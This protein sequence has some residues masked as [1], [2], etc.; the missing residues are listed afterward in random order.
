[1]LHHDRDRRTE[2]DR[3]HRGQRTQADELDHSGRLDFDRG[4][5][6]AGRGDDDRG[7][8]GDGQ[9]L[10][11]E[12][13]GEQH[14]HGAEHGGDR[15]DHGQRPHGKRVVEADVRDRGADAEKQ[16]HNRRG[17]RRRERFAKPFVQRRNLVEEVER[18]V[19]RPAR[20]ILATRLAIV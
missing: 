15:A 5:H 8:L 10:A 2:Q 12:K 19:D 9:T 13:N 6:R 14:G 4:Q 7:G 18:G 17:Q 16:T 1:M 3:S 20:V 11:E